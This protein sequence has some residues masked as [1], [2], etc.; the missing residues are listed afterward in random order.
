V[1]VSLY[2][3]ICIVQPSEVSPSLALLEFIRQTSVDVVGLYWDSDF[4]RR[5]VWSWIDIAWLGLQSVA[6]AVGVPPTLSRTR[7]ADVLP[8]IVLWLV[9]RLATYGVKQ[10]LPLPLQR[11]ATKHV[12]ADQSTTWHSCLP[13]LDGFLATHMHWL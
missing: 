5:S 6:H 12:L 3:K 4:I 11:C 8:V 7:P 10:E 1:D 2:S 9:A 13:G